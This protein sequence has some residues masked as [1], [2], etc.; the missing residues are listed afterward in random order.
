MPPTEA[1]ETA[2]G[3]VRSQFLVNLLKSCNRQRK[4]ARQWAMNS[5]GSGNSFGKRQGNGNGDANLL[6]NPNGNRMCSGNS[7][8]KPLSQRKQQWELVRHF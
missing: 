8:G 3:S 7:F 1:V 2:L 5:I 6:E 4:L